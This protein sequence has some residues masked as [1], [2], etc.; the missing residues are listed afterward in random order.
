MS[1][2]G[3]SEVTWATFPGLP[4]C[5]CL[6]GHLKGCRL[7]IT[8]QLWLPNPFL[9]DVLTVC[10]SASVAVAVVVLYEHVHFLEFYLKRKL[11]QSFETG[12]KWETMCSS[13]AFL[14]WSVLAVSLSFCLVSV[15][16]FSFPYLC[17]S[18]QETKNPSP[19]TTQVEWKLFDVEFLFF[20]FFVW[21][22]Q[23]LLALIYWC[24]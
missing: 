19:Q 3:D 21:V 5:S 24:T 22:S 16:L 10:A 20:F 14:L 7:N 9:S 11:L 17:L 4:Q 18:P 23:R 1:H 8:A 15:L 12:T 13:T 6:F 2:W